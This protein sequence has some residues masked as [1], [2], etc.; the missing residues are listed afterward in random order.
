[1]IVNVGKA[2]NRTSQSA[3]SDVICNV[4]INPDLNH[5]ARQGED[6][7][8][9]SGLEM[10]MLEPSVDP[11]EN[12]TVD[13]KIERYKEENPFSVSKT[14][15]RHMMITDEKTGKTLYLDTMSG[16]TSE[17]RPSDWFSEL[18]KFYDGK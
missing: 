13:E 12:L 10:S 6:E 1:M 7:Y 8:E 2:W 16:E 4:I 15:G 3:I 18:K 17:R 11:E 14:V 9:S 5:A